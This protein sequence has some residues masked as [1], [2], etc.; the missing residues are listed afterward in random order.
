MAL[1]TVLEYPDKRL[2]LKAAAVLAIDAKIQK[3]VDDMLETMYK[4]NGIGLAATQVNIHQRI[5]VMDLSEDKS[6]PLCLINPEIV[7]A[8]GVQYEF[9]G[10]ISFPGMYDKVERAAKVKLRALDRHGDTFEIDA[11]ALL[12]VCIQHEIDHLNGV[13]FMDHLSRLK[14]DRMIR[15]LEK[16]RARA[17]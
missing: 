5:I 4:E 9:E 11:E 10:C 6:T 1:L 7:S 3:I 2:R 12:A 8:E 15:K 13:L 16:D 17:I 14:Q